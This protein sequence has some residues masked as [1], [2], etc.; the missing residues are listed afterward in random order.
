MASIKK[1]LSLILIFLFA[2][3]SLTSCETDDGNNSNGQQET[4][5]DSFSEYFGNDISR[6]F[7][8]NVIDSNKNPIEGVTITIGNET[9]L[10]DSNGI[11][12]INSTNVNERFGYVKAEKSG[13][14]HGSRSVV[15]SGGTNKVT[16][17][18]LEAT[19]VGTVNSGSSETISV[20]NGSSVSFDGNFIK[21]DGSAYS[22]SVDVIMHH[23]DPADKDMA[24]Q[25]PGMLYAQNNEGAERMLQTLGMLAIELRGTGGEDLNLGEGSISEIKMPVD[26]SLMSI[27]P[28][29]I[30]LWYFDEVNGYWKEEGQA[31]LQ[32]NMYVGNVSHFSFWNCDIPAEAITL[33]I[34][35]TNESNNSL[36]NLWVSITSTTFGTTYGYTNENGE[37]CGYV[38]SN[39][40]LELNIYSYDFCGDTPL[41]YEMIGPFSTDSNISIIVQ[42]SSD[43]IEET[44]IGNF[45]SC[46]GDAV[47]DGYVQLTYGYQ[48]YIDLVT[49]GE[50]EIN[51]LRCEEDNT[52]KLKGSDYVNLQT[53]DSISYTFTTPLTNIGS[54]SACNTVTEFIQYS[55]DDGE[56][57]LIIDGFQTGFSEASDAVD[58][59]SLTISGSSNTGNCFYMF[60]NLDDTVY[61]GSYDYFDWNDAN[62]TGFNIQECIDM[63]ST[64][65]NII[66]NLTTLGAAGEYIDINFSGAY[67]DYNGNPHTI[68]GVVHVFRDY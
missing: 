60:G 50:F 6:D 14:I 11:F 4:I 24:M 7:I 55:I 37:V 46:N 59:P 40:T 9:V 20:A 65:N 1:I 48:T 38:P 28:A 2:L 23:L 42:E 34:T 49:N 18:L 54:I 52:F 53:T 56:T 30:P 68:T 22:G 5:P 10:T 64:N 19:V 13:Y 32:G 57:V 36:S 15:P 16:I 35:A 45:N 26:A 29:T 3:T 25:M 27:A 67:E 51:L 43:I 58:G 66:F 31:T 21:E 63:T 33:C 44:I 39:E 61:E 17:M 62:D 41:Y 8:G 12:I 47:N